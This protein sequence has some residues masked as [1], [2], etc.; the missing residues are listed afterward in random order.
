MR[1]EI[2]KQGGIKLI[3]IDPPFDVGADFTMDIEIGDQTF[4]KNPGILEEIAF[5][6][7]W[8]K[9][10][11]TF[12]SMIYER[13][14]LIRD[15]LA[16]DGSIYV[17]CDW[18][19]NS[20]IREILDEIFGTIYFKNEIIWEKIKSVKAQTK[21]FGNKKD[22]IFYFS[23][24]NSFIFNQQKKDHK[25]KYINEKY[26]SE[27]NGRKYTL[28][29]FTQK[30]PGEP[31]D[32]GEYGILTPPPGKHWIWTQDRITEGLK[33]NLF[34]FSKN[35]VPRVKRYLDEVEGESIGDIWDDLNPID[36]MSHE[37]VGYP[38][39]KPETLLTR[40]LKS[41][42]N[43]NDLIADFFC[44]S[45]TTAAV[46]EKLGR[47]WI[48]TDLGK[49]A[50][51][52]TRKRL[53]G[54]QRELKKAGKPYR[55]FEVLNLGKYERQHFV[56]V[57]PNLREEDRIK[58]QEAKEAAFV[59]LILRAYK[60]EKVEG[61]SAFHGK[62][63]NRMVVVGPVNLPVT[64]LFVEE[65]ILESRKNRFT[66]VD[67]SAKTPLEKNLWIWRRDHFFS[68]DSKKNSY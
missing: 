60:P 5:R 44:G 3:Y 57:N 55:S 62:K 1:D 46:A 63:G 58:Q 45:G 27:D 28:N 24:T 9:G 39:Q 33:N 56:S 67:R 29:S 66:I 23:K 42:S 20:H 41:A 50:I 18:R 64:R 15:L 14:V 17:H 6:D 47:K 13:L 4:T 30:G 2:E 8:G 54:V 26:S 48:A 43:Q 59:D 10:I 61:F 7:T 32:F 12:I 49:F 52:T 34:I 65:I 16:E 31:K 11:D 22:T 53:L 68:A 19:V 35:N 37:R 38:T 36:S 40:I 51:H 25:I 21:G